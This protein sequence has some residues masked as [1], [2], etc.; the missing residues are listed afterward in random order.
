MGSEFE[1]ASVGM[2]LREATTLPKEVWLSV[3]FSPAALVD[4]HAASALAHA[5]RDI[6]IE[7]TERAVVE[8]YPALRR[9]LDQMRRVQL[10]VDDAG[11]AYA[12]LRNILELR[13]DIVKLDMA[14]VRDVDTDPA[15]RALVIGMCHFAAL[16][17]IKL[18]AEGVETRAEADTLASLGVQW[19]Q[20]YLFGR[21]RAE[22]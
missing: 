16:S 6:V 20:G 4:G 9:A 22:W 10:S 1:A 12:G 18:V 19:G 3:N 8:N 5:D 11:A 7:V 14:L 21:P 13:P 2:I 17:E 15:R